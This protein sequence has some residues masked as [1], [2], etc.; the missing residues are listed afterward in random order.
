MARVEAGN[1]TVA[2]GEFEQ[3]HRRGDWRYDGF[4]FRFDRRQ[5]EAAIAEIEE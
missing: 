4:E 3:P 2:W 1:E 5:Y